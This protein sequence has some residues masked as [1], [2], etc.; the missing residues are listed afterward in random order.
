MKNFWAEKIFGAKQGSNI[1][2]GS[3]DILSYPG[4]SQGGKLNKEVGSKQQSCTSSKTRLTL[5]T[6]VTAHKHHGHS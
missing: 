2:V 6:V 5:W 3:S 4:Y 1:K